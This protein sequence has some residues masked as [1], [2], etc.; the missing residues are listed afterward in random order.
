MAVSHGHCWL[1]WE[2]GK[3]Q[4][5][6]KKPK[7]QTLSIPKNGVIFLHKLVLCCSHSYWKFH[8]DMLWSWV[9]LQI[10]FASKICGQRKHSILL[11]S[12]PCLPWS[13]CQRFCHWLCGPRIF[14]H[15]KFLKVLKSMQYNELFP[16]FMNQVM[17]TKTNMNAVVIFFQVR[18]NFLRKGQR[19][20]LVVFLQC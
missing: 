12:H 13:W 15:Y 10:E 14:Q 5:K 16:S 20:L 9:Y 1:N 19:H 3:L 11:L 17:A 8:Y 4:K 2:I 18:N 7:S 6:F